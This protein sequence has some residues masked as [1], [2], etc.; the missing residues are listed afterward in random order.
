MSVFGRLQFN[1]DGPGIIELSNN[2]LS[3]LNTVPQ[4]LEPWQMG[5]MANNEVGGYHTNPVATSSQNIRNTC[6][7]LV[8]FLSGSTAN[9]EGNLTVT[10]PVTSNDAPT[11]VLFTNINSLSANIGG[12]NGGVFIEHTNRISGVTKLQDSIVDGQD[13]TH[14]PHYATAMGVG[15][16][17]TYLTHQ[18]DNIANSA[19][20]SG[21]FTSMFINDALEDLELTISTYEA[22]INS[23]LS[24][25]S[26]DDGNG[27]VTIVRISSLP[28]STVNAMSNVISTINTTMAERRVHDERFYHNSQTLADEYGELKNYSKS[29][30]A[31]ANN[32]LHNYNGS[33]KLLSR[34]DS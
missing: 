29:M 33:D 24:I 12:P 22:T 4:L 17:I 32:M 23:S 26:T 25:S 8:I 20:I 14:L 18:S 15:Q 11:A 21:S 27:N 10:G 2:V 31:T 13:R 6:N 1:Y 19:A 3:F 30:G 16:M 7:N 9:I 5:D 34:L 28:Y